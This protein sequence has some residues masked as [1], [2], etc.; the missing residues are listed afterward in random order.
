MRSFQWPQMFNTNSSRIW[1]EED[2]L[3]ATKQNAVIL[4]HCVRGELCGDPYFG[5]MLKHFLFNQNN[6]ALRDQII[7]I[8]YTQLAIFMP[9]IRV[10]RNDIEIIQDKEKGKLYCNFH[11]ISQIDY[12]VQTFNLVLLENTENY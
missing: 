2:H 12:Q 6:Y 5:L 4:L 1:K 3:V 8:I 10:K 7:D 9:Q 11:A